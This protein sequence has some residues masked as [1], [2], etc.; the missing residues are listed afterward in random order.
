[1]PHTWSL[2]KKNRTALSDLKLP[3]SKSSPQSKNG[4]NL[5]KLSGNSQGDDCLDP[6]SR[7]ST[8]SESSSQNTESHSEQNQCSNY[9]SLQPESTNMFSQLRVRLKAVTAPHAER[10][11][12]VCRDFGRQTR[13]E[14][15]G[16]DLET[17]TIIVHEHEKILGTEDSSNCK[18]QNTTTEEGVQNY[19]HL[20]KQYRN[21]NQT[22]ILLNSSKLS[23]N[24][25]L[26]SVPVQCD[27]AN[28][29]HS[30]L[31]RNIHA[32]RGND[33]AFVE[34]SQYKTGN[35]IL[36]NSASGSQTSISEPQNMF[37][38][39]PINH[40][41]DILKTD[42]ESCLSISKHEIIRTSL[43][44]LQTKSQSLPVVADSNRNSQQ[45]YSSNN[46]YVHSQRDSE[47]SSL[48][49]I[50][51]P[52]SLGLGNRDV[53]QQNLS[54]SSLSTSQKKDGAD[55]L[56]DSKSK[57]SH[58][59]VHIPHTPLFS[60]YTHSRWNIDLQNCDDATFQR[61]SSNDSLQTSNHRPLSPLSLSEPVCQ[62]RATSFMTINSKT[63]HQYSGSDDT[64][65]NIQSTCND[66]LQSSRDRS[67]RTP[68]F[69]F[70]GKEKS[71]VDNLTSNETRVEPVTLRDADGPMPE[72]ENNSWK[73]S[74]ENEGRSTS[75]LP[76]ELIGNDCLQK[77]NHE[78]SH[79]LPAD[80][81]C[82]TNI[83]HHDSALLSNQSKTDGVSLDSMGTASSQNGESEM[84]NATEMAITQ[85]PNHKTFGSQ[86]LSS[87][88][89]ALLNINSKQNNRPTSGITLS[90]DQVLS[91]KF[92]VRSTYEY[93]L[94][95]DSV[96]STDITAD[97]TV[98]EHKSDS[99]CVLSIS[100]TN[101]TSPSDISMKNTS[102]NWPSHTVNSNLPE[103]HSVH[104]VQ[105][106]KFE[107][108][109]LP[110]VV[111][112]CSF[113]ITNKGNSSKYY[114]NS[115]NS[116]DAQKNVSETV[117]EE[118]VTS[119]LKQNTLLTYSS[120]KGGNEYLPKDKSNNNNKLSVRDSL[121]GQ[122]P[123]TN[124]IDSQ[125]KSLTNFPLS[126]NTTMSPGTIKNAENYQSEKN[127][128]ISPEDLM[129]DLRSPTNTRDN[130]DKLLIH[131]PMRSGVIQ[132]LE[133]GQSENYKVISL[134][135]TP[136][137][138]KTPS[139]ITHGT[140]STLQNCERNS[141]DTTMLRGIIKDG[142]KTD[143]SKTVGA[144]SILDP[145]FNQLSLVDNRHCNEHKPLCH[146]LSSVDVTRNRNSLDCLKN[147][148]S[149]SHAAV[150]SNK[151]AHQLS[152]I[153]TTS[154]KDQQL[155]YLPNSAEIS[156]ETEQDKAKATYPSS[157][158]G[159]AISKPSTA[160]NTPKYRDESLNCS[161]NNS[162]FTVDTEFKKHS[163]KDN[164]EISGVDLSAD[165]LQSTAME[166]LPESPAAIINI[167]KNGLGHYS[168][169][170]TDA[171]CD[172]GPCDQYKSKRLGKTDQALSSPP[173]M[174]ALWLT[175]NIIPNNQNKPLIHPLHSNDIYA[176]SES[177]QFLQKIKSESHFTDPS[178]EI[179]TAL[180]STVTDIKKGAM[181]IDPSKVTE[182]AHDERT[183]DKNVETY[184]SENHGATS[185]GGVTGQR[186]GGEESQQHLTPNNGDITLDR[187]LNKDN[188]QQNKSE[189]AHISSAMDSVIGQQFST[190]IPHGNKYQSLNYSPNSPAV[191]A[192]R[193][194]NKHFQKDNT[195]P[196]LPDSLSDQPSPINPHK[197]LTHFPLSDDNNLGAEVTK[198]AGN[199]QPGESSSIPSPGA[200]N[201]QKSPPNSQSN[202]DKP[203][204]RSLERG[205][206]ETNENLQQHKSIISPVTSPVYP[207]TPPHSAVGA[208]NVK[209][210]TLQHY[211][212]KVTDIYHRKRPTGK[213]K[214]NVLHKTKS[215]PSPSAAVTS[216]WLPENTPQSS[217]EDKSKTLSL[218]RDD[219]SLIAGSETTETCQSDKNSAVSSDKLNG[220]WTRKNI[221]Q[222]RRNILQDPSLNI[223]GITVDRE[224]NNT[225]DAVNTFETKSMPS[226]VNQVS[227]QLYPTDIAHRYEDKSLSHWVNNVAVNVHRESPD[228][229]EKCKH[230][231]KSALLSGDKVT[232]QKSLASTIHSYKD[233]LL[234]YS[235]AGTD[236]NSIN[237]D[238]F[239][240]RHILP[241][242]DPMSSYRSS[243]NVADSSKCKTSNCSLNCASVTADIGVNEHLQKD[244][245]ETNTIL[246]IDSLHDIKSTLTITDIKNDKR[247]CNEP[248]VTEI[249]P[250][251]ESLDLFKISDEANSTPLS[252]TPV[253]SEWFPTILSH[254]NKSYSQPHSPLSGNATMDRG[255]DEYLQKDIRDLSTTPGSLTDQQFPTT[256]RNNSMSKSATHSPFRS[257][258]GV[259]NLENYQSGNHGRI[260]QD[261]ETDQR[262]P[263]NVTP[264]EKEMQQNLS[265]NNGD[266]TLDRRLNKGNIQQNKSEI[267][268]ISAA[269]SVIGQR[270][271]TT[272]PRRNKYQSLNYSPNSPAVTADRGSNKQLQKDNTGPTLPDSLSDQPSPINPHKPLT[273]FPLSD[274]NNLG[275]EVT[276]NAGNA[277]PGESSSIPSPGALSDQK[278]PPTNSQSNFD[279]PL[280]RS[281]ERGDIETNENLQ[282]HNTI[283]SP[284]TSPVYLFTPPHLAV[285]AANVKKNTL[286]HYVTKVTDIYHRKRPTGKFKL[287]VLHKT[288]SAPS[289]SAAVTS[290]WLPENTP[291]SS[292]EDKSKT[293]SLV[294]D[295][296][297]LIA[298][299]ETTETCQSDKN[300]AVSSDKLNGQ[301]TRKNITEGRRNVLQDP[302]LNID[303]I[304]VDREANNTCDAVNT[305]ETKSM[306]STVN[307]VSSQLYPTDIV[308]S[309]ED[310]SLS[311]WVNNV[312]INVHRESPDYLEKCKHETKSALLSGDKVT[313]Q[314][315]PTRTTHGYKDMPLSYLPARTDVD[316]IN[317]DYNRDKFKTS[318]RIA[319]LYPVSSHHSPQ[320]HTNKCETVNCSLNCATVSADIG[321]N[322]HLKVD[323]LETNTIPAL[324]SLN[325]TQSTTTITDIKKNLRLNYSSHLTETY[326]DKIPYKRL[327]FKDLRKTNSAPSSPSKMTGHWLTTDIIHNNQDK[328]STHCTLSGEFITNR[329]SNSCLQK[330]KLETGDEFSLVE[331]QSPLNIRKS[332]PGKSP[333]HSPNRSDFVMDTAV[334]RNLE[335]CQPKN[336]RRTFLLP[337]T[338]IAWDKNT[339]FQ[340]CFPTSDQS[341]NEQC[342]VN[343]KRYKSETDNTVS[344]RDLLIDQDSFISVTCSKKSK[345]LRETTRSGDITLARRYYGN[346]EQLNKDLINDI[347]SPH[348][349]S[350]TLLSPTDIVRN[351][352]NVTCDHSPNRVDFPAQDFDNAKRDGK[353]FRRRR[354]AF[355]GET[356]QNQTMGMKNANIS[357]SPQQSSPNEDQIDSNITELNNFRNRLNAYN[358]FYQFRASS[359]SFDEDDTVNNNLG[360]GTSR[361]SKK[362]CRFTRSPR[363]SPQNVPRIFDGMYKAK[364][365]KDINS[366]YNQSPFQDHENVFSTSSLHNP[367]LT[368][369]NRQSRPNLQVSNCI[370]SRRLSQS[371]SDLPS[372]NENEPDYNNWTSYHGSKFSE[373]LIGNVSE[374]EKKEETHLKN[375]KRVLVEDKLWKPGYLHKEAS[376]PRSEDVFNP[377]TSKVNQD[378][379][380]NDDAGQNDE[381]FPVDIK[382]FWPKENP[383]DIMRLLSSSSTGS[384]ISEDSLSPQQH[385]SPVVIDKRNFSC[386]SDTNSDTTTDDEYFLDGNG[387]VKESAL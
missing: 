73:H 206:I 34:I 272:I 27:I 212:T 235:S 285:G 254:N 284:V 170:V 169:N 58:V 296:I 335:N 236:V 63:K 77:V 352:R 95:D 18:L 119:D 148:K 132:N 343:M 43:L 66:H 233:K 219:I 324:G 118:P 246:A 348:D 283:I 342:D 44:D 40:T 253:T 94:L 133:N 139:G 332:K 23:E 17:K 104:D 208:A 382:I 10:K 336:N 62:S 24:A 298:G 371:Y 110:S 162:T 166:Y 85:S 1:M 131:S 363:P 117:N 93:L 65:I 328:S 167:R 304:T 291:Q 244:S 74:C 225:C 193:G 378:P 75:L 155:N 145:V 129:S 57:S 31:S 39:Q 22:N 274:D 109:T 195:G 154:N 185:L 150:V 234:S 69:T 125:D 191:T 126:D 15:H 288:K 330:Y 60:I 349:L 32:F 189:I 45:S 136:T 160:T 12:H 124:F 92:H 130:M 182:I 99:N 199:A 153:D 243:K 183:S 227:S 70:T 290:Q 252:L 331:Q 313:Q 71:S 229:L 30:R 209:K 384:K 309:N 89:N 320:T 355:C 278:S 140:K 50:T 345:Y 259:N 359:S 194:S 111:V 338:D 115:E 369:R 149:E 20:T 187:R 362:H 36:P 312:A 381:Y 28:V 88:N 230:E 380:V 213:F 327:N 353:I 325:D 21:D 210:N 4:I 98:N 361:F 9:N 174:T 240:S 2:R 258:G 221:T 204:T 144:L 271:S 112:Q 269:D 232:Q 293:L 364:S 35:A 350:P 385:H 307:Q 248:K 321:V 164:S 135:D 184:Q 224:A 48:N 161:F 299:S 266:I 228:Y 192:D 264:T 152:P 51:G 314:K 55:Y 273:H 375:L 151:G 128:P 83:I 67:E 171:C 81:K 340:N 146:P 318:H 122:E 13:S 247:F 374:E 41:D 64:N 326:H 377:H 270:F 372:S 52:R 287:N 3:Q 175:S 292:N 242:L 308:H 217:N 265:P 76:T 319:S 90:T 147:S 376:S 207:F 56:N 370:K 59:S 176:E 334:I 100:D 329:R 218:V 337:D 142:K 311:H 282:Q 250:D 165:P 91:Y 346:C 163:Q 280:I 223:D 358:D 351:N 198:N 257:P 268:H 205:D 158:L 387:T 267:P 222:G 263:T 379:G 354:K 231:T 178:P 366:D 260:S 357:T 49:S 114:P 202:F 173:G 121:S 295:D 367:K 42:T 286:Q 101:E 237:R 277:Q 347:S 386:Y 19:N 300:S 103:I 16:Q 303:G 294:R 156:R 141:A 123:R 14:V 86:S 159:P 276:K 214:L 241:A 87:T 315:S 26:Q 79:E 383:S 261:R 201:D 262:T 134:S 190:A 106:Y 373:L 239:Y 203:L 322:E 127:I 297:S 339:K 215:A 245:P 238:E 188:I 172:E 143:K 84:S 256:S 46:I 8:S 97:A 316:V 68:L 137:D 116:N 61:D 368:V 226:T 196:T 317:Q 310:K 37:Q 33:C 108:T 82:V 113:T 341:L 7:P 216:Q 72:S 301:R 177:N 6:A 365:L 279:K 29:K 181:H 356:F 107:K 138:L 38:N 306:P 11:I 105:N 197:P 220:Q 186:T 360:T 78:T 255:R 120:L 54:N 47:S 96:K 157:C 275:A 305:F 281:L 344:S 323:S 211:V 180:Q 302:S 5:I 102:Q 251:K 289:P 179:L 80:P 53:Q 168:R 333:V 249:V 200:L 25:E